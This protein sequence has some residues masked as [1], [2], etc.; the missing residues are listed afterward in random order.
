MFYINLQ[1]IITLTNYL[2]FLYLLSVT[3]KKKIQIFQDKILTNEFSFICNENL[4][5]NSLQKSTDSLN[6]KLQIFPPPQR[7]LKRGRP[8]DLIH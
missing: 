3:L 1:V 6:F 4:L 8:H 2:Y 5:Q 7:R